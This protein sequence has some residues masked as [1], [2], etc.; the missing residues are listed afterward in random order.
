MKKSVPTFFDKKINYIKKHILKIYTEILDSIFPP[1]CGICGKINEK[2]LCK[3]CEKRINKLEIFYLIRI[4]NNHIFLKENKLFKLIKSKNCKLKKYKMKNSTRNFNKNIQINKI[5]F[6]ELLY[7]FRYSG[8]IRKIILKYK[9]NDCAYLYNF[10]CTIIFNKENC[11]R[12][13]KSYDIIIPVPMY[14]KKKKQR[15]YNQT[16]LITNKIAEKLEIKLEKN[17]IIKIK[18]TKTQ[19]T[20]SESERKQNIKNAFLVNNKENILGKKVIIFDDI[21]T[22]GQTVNELSKKLKLAGAKEIIVFVLAKD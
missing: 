14:E 9:F 4:N 13:L 12:K 18:N 21:Y 2:W 1:V 6:D 5:Y 17:N 11:C 22:T 16:E 15:G 10:F 20:L 19:S 7:V 8:L 3:N